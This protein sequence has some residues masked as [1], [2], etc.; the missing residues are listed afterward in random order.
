VSAATKEGSTGRLA[1]GALA[2]ALVAVALTGSNSATSPTGAAAEAA[3]D[4]GADRFRGEV[5]LLGSKARQRIKRNS[6]RPGCPVP[7]RKLRAVKVTHIDFK[8]RSRRGKLIVHQ[9]YA[10]QILHAFKRLHHKRF[11]I[12]RIKPIDAYGGS[13]H[14][15]MGADNTSAFNCRYVAGTSRWSMHA[16]GKAI[17]INPRENPY[18]TPSGHVSPPEGAPYADRSRKGKGMIRK[19]GVVVRV[20]RR[21]V[22]WKWGGNWKGTKDYQHFSSNGR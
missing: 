13:D 19:R 16:Y 6:W 7:L 14:A 22:G 18:V 15:S 17:D 10:H 3:A 4:R 8:R 1:A 5:K 11:P 9:R 2:A 21:M 12:R 20:F